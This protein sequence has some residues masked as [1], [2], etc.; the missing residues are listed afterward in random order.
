MHPT[1]EQLAEVVVRSHYHECEH[2]NYYCEV[3]VDDEFHNNEMGGEEV[4]F[5]M[6]RIKSEFNPLLYRNDWAGGKYICE[7]CHDSLHDMVVPA[8]PR[9]RNRKS[10]KLSSK[11]ARVRRIPA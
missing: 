3:S 5:T 8:S 6:Y 9:P 2:N 7:R 1:R 4:D 10:M 11:A